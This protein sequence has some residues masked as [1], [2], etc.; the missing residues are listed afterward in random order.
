LTRR[1][2]PYLL[3]VLAAC[4]GSPAP[5]TPSP[6]TP[7]D[8]L[9]G[10]L[11]AVRQNDLSR[12]GQLW[13]SERGPAAGWMDPEELNKR[14]AVMQKYLAHGGYRV[15][16]GPMPIPGESRRMSFRVELRRDDCVHVQA[17]DV[18]RVDRGGW[19]VQDVHLGEARSPVQACPSGTGTPR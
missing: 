12:M 2:V 16:E 6:A 13:G 3:A 19:V 8:A 15:V 11:D 18:V 14:V 4:G 5:A 7:A 10:F 1:L 9:A 17:M